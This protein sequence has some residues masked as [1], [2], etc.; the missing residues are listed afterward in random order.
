MTLADPAGAATITE[1]PAS[2]AGNVVL[3]ERI[4]AGPDGNLWWTQP[5]KP[6]GIGR[7][8]PNGELLAQI[9]DGQVPLDLVKAPSGWVSW[10]SRGGFGSRRPDGTTFLN[11][12][13]SFFPS[14][15]AITPTGELR[16]GGKHNKDAKSICTP[17][18]A[19][20][21]HVEVPVGTCVGAETG[22]RPMAMAASAG[23]LLWASLSESD[24]IW[25]TKSAPLQSVMTVDLP[26]GSNPQGIAI[27]PEGNAWVAMWGADAIDRIAPTGA[28]TRFV[29]PPGSHP[30]D[31]TLGPDGAFWIAAAGSGRIARMTTGGLVTNE[32]PV[33][34]GETGQS[35]IT[36]GPEGNIWFTDT[37]MGLIGRLVP[38][39]LTTISPSPGP[40]PGSPGGSGGGTADKVAPRF[41]SAPA[42]SPT[43]FRVP[44]GTTL[45][46]SL[47]E[48][49]TVTVTVSRKV[50]GRRSG[51]KCVAPGKAKPG[52]S[53]C[54][55]L[56]PKGQLHV[57]GQMGRN[58]VRFSGKLNGKSL[59]PGSY[60]SSLTARDSAGN[61]SIAAKANFTIVN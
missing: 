51:R 25:I 17:K 27:G 12:D 45:K 59:P 32:Y 1:F 37:E 3:P 47:S 19:N 35:G 49:A 5:A 40:A 38:D 7:M 21:D 55:R 36:V 13:E 15:I 8:V 16:F 57:A 6:S 9:P 10:V 39:P 48:A 11:Y 44:P 61:S 26:V 20:S 56:V 42:F 22:G 52:A 14:A 23:N 33:P 29:L 18:L 4:I 54:P 34:S 60:Q 46:F 28:R 2:D 30:Y 24:Q 41:S 53:R 31:L 58:S 43:S 50:S